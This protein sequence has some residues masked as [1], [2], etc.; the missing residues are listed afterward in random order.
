MIFDK[1]N[2]AAGAAAGAALVFVTYTTFNALL[3][4]P[5]AREE[6][7][8]LERAAALAK[9]IELIQQRSKT[10]VE[11]GKLG[12]DALCRELGG[13]WMHDPDRCE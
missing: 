8:A 12:D 11:I 1:L 7:R 4:L 6:G 5:A 13:V 3:I 9:S 2:L 10:N